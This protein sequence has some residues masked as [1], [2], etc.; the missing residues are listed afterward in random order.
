V[1]TL[2]RGLTRGLLDE[3]A[4]FARLTAFVP[5]DSE[6]AGCLI[7]IDVLTASDE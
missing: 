2:H 7:E 5:E 3:L 6:R 1:C 4:P